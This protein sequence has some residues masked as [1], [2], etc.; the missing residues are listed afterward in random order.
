MRYVGHLACMEKKINY[1]SFSW[2]NWNERGHKEAL[3]TSGRTK[4]N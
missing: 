4:L 3:S 1:K 2:E